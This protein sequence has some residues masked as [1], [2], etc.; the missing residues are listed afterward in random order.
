MKMYFGDKT[1]FLKTLC[2]KI[3]SKRRSGGGY[4]LSTFRKIKSSK[5]VFYRRNTFRKHRKLI[6]LPA[7]LIR[8]IEYIHI[9][10]NG[11]P[12]TAPSQPRPSSARVT[13]LSCGSASSTWLSSTQWWALPRPAPSRPAPTV[14]DRR[15][16]ASKCVKMLQI[17]LWYICKCVSNIP[18]IYL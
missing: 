9:G 4:I 18:L 6:N 15:G 1:C 7:N 8:N 14:W 12:P 5:N 2:F 16:I 11:G 17:Y 10:A 3:L 13:L